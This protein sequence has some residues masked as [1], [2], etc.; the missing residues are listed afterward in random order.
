MGSGVTI[1]ERIDTSINSVP[2]LRKTRCCEGIRVFN[3]L[4]N[5]IGLSGKQPDKREISQAMC[6]IA[7]CDWAVALAVNREERRVHPT[8]KAGR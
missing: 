3:F 4:S 8:H 2:K 7:L 5:K 1:C 6:Q